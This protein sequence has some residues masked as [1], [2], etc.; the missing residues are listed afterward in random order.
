[1]R[2]FVQL[3][4]L[5]IV[6]TEDPPFVSCPI[7]IGTLKPFPDQGLTSVSLNLCLIKDSHLYP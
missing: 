5:N 2:Y 1:M 4:F 6:Q 3:S 7:H